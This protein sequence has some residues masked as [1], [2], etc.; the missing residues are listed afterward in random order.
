MQI[1]TGV[2]GTD[3]VRPGT[4]VLSRLALAIHWRALF[5]A[6]KF[7]PIIIGLLPPDGLM[8]VALIL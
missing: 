5:A 2:E 4:T 7:L 6:P 3:E 1:G 8:Q